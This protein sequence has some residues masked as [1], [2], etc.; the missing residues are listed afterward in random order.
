MKFPGQP[1][2][3]RRL[4][5]DGMLLRPAA[6]TRQEACCRHQKK[7]HEAHLCIPDG[8]REGSLELKN[9]RDDCNDKKTQRKKCNTRNPLKTLGSYDQKETVCTRKAAIEVSKTPSLT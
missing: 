9:S 5:P 7:F 6:Q 2:F 8:A 1:V 3:G 4:H